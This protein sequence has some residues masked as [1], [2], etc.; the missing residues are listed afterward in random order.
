[1]QYVILF[2]TSK[3]RLYE[4]QMQETAYPQVARE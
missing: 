3:Q 2:P 1:M 4:T